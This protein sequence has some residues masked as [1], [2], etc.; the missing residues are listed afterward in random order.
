MGFRKEIE[1]KWG[2]A[3]L[4]WKMFKRKTGNYCF[5]KSVGNFKT[6]SSLSQIYV[7]MGHCFLAPGKLLSPYLNNL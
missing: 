5:E 4:L 2:T 7:Y 1:R 6:N 3:F